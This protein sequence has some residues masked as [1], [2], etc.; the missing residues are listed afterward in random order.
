MK[1]TKIQNVLI[2][3]VA[4]TALSACGGDKSESLTEKAINKTKDIASSA[5]YK[6]GMQLMQLKNH[7]PQQRSSASN[8]VT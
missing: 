4:L 7:K 8:G 5:K 6:A 2:T 1:R 3:F